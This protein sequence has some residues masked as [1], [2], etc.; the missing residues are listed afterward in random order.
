MNYAESKEQQELFRLASRHTH[1]DG[2]LADYMFAIP[3]GGTRGGRA[4]MLAGVRRKAEGVKSGV[5]DVFLFDP[6][7]EYHGLFIEMKKSPTDGGKLSDVSG[8]QHE[9]IGL[10]RS[11]G[12]A[13][14]VALG[15]VA[16]WS[17]ILVYLRG[18]SP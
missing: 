15:C 6:V 4:A 7:G 8:A 5:S 9:F 13:C 18:E 14:V 1:R 2:V 16:A 12:Y 17:K 3:N 10:A 11:R